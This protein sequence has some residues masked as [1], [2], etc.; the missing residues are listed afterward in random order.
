MRTST[1]H[2]GK[3]QTL[4][5]AKNAFRRRSGRRQLS[6][7]ELA[8]AERREILAER[9]R[10]IHERE[11][12]KRVNARKKAEKM[13]KEREML[14]RQGR[15]LPV[16]EGG[17]KIGP[18]QMELDWFVGPVERM[19]SCEENGMKEM[20]KENVMVETVPA[21]KTRATLTQMFRAPKKT[22]EKKTRDPVIEDAKILKVEPSEPEERDLC[23]KPARNISNAP[24][25]T[26]TTNRT[27]TS[28]QSP[29]LSP[30]NQFQQPP[31]FLKP[32][33]PASHLRPPP[34]P[35]TRSILKPQ[36]KTQPPPDDLTDFM[37]PSNTQIS[38]EI[39]TTSVP[40]HAG[41][42]LLEV[43]GPSLSTS[44]GLTLPKS[45]EPTLP[46]PNDLNFLLSSLSSQDLTYTPTQAPPPTPPPT[47]QNSRSATRPVTPVSRAEIRS[48]R[49]S[50]VDVGKKSARNRRTEREIA[51]MRVQG[52]NSSSNSNSS[53]HKDCNRSGNENSN[54][55][56]NNGN[57]N[58]GNDNSSNTNTNNTNS[59]SSNIDYRTKS[60]SISRNHNNK[61]NSN[62]NE[63]ASGNANSNNNTTGSFEYGDGI[64]DD[65][66]SALAEEVEA[67]ARSSG[68]SIMSFGSISESVKED[69]HKDGEQKHWDQQR[70][71]WCDQGGQKIGGRRGWDNKG[72]AGMM[73]R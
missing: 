50:R 31:S 43:P 10:K 71:L 72:R 30:R 26:T 8:Q 41:P 2:P 48:G 9:A 44:A 17:I 52:S 57:S 3:P 19:E 60:G 32:S 37:F 21:M 42:S 70:H 56:S 63:N 59:N 46:S 38:R 65:D 23:P 54:S 1:N 24:I 34:R 13:E 53:V 58:N 11:E 7:R 6:E 33:L 16:K 67:Y 15:A 66:L 47:L 39:S 28:K 27:A 14:V 20:K 55:N 12:R 62:G 4:R 51:L 64:A 18:S 49:D 25:T 29:P 68:E 22:S 36:P 73:A 45:A 69:L 61:G 35:Q 5:Q 40:T